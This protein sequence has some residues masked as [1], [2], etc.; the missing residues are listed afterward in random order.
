MDKGNTEEMNVVKA[1]S[2]QIIKQLTEA[3]QSQKKV[4]LKHNEFLLVGMI[5]DYQDLDLCDRIRKQFQLQL[6]LQEISI[7]LICYEQ[8]LGF[9]LM[10]KH[11]DQIELMLNYQIP[12]HEVS[13]E[14]L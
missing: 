9:Q 12:Y 13:L 10:S 14:L 8:F 2:T 11:S 5:V 7:F 1:T 3:F 6:S 4:R